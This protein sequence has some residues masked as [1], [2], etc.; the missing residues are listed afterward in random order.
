MLK[1]CPLLPIISA[2]QRLYTHALSSMVHKTAT[3]QVDDLKMVM[4]QRT[5]GIYAQVSY[6]KRVDW[7]KQEIPT[8]NC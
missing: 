8:L 6:E 7:E 2:V 3:V 4:E 1:S 5:M